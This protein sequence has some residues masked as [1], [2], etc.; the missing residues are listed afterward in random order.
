MLD[1]GPTDELT[2]VAS[3]M[4]GR[5]DGDVVRVRNYGL[6]LRPEVIRVPVYQAEYDSLVKY[7]TD[8]A[9]D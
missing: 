3:M 2:N 4:Y 5:K 6:I 9:Q 1:L 8:L 7:L